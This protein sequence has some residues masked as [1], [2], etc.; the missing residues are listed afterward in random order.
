MAKVFDWLI[1]LLK[2]LEIVRGYA[3]DLL[4]SFLPNRH[5]KV[6]TN[7]CIS[8]Y[9]TGTFFID[10]N[11]WLIIMPDGNMVSYEA[12][13]MPLVDDDYR[14][15]VK[16]QMDAYHHKVIYPTHLE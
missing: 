8:D 9:D 15:Q 16:K 13:T 7:N 4:Y 12:G 5:Q 3:L 1:N 6:N 10:V 2:E 11:V 14:L